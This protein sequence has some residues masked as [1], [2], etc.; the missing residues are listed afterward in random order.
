MKLAFSHDT[1]RPGQEELFT[2]VANALAQKKH[3]LAHAPTGIGKTAAVLTPALDFALHHDLTIFFLTSRHTQHNIVL[4]TVHKLNERN[5]THFPVTSLIGKKHLCAQENVSTMPASDFTSFCKTL[6]EE[7][8]CEY[9]TN[10]RGKNNLAAQQL[11]QILKMGPPVSSEQVMARSAQH[12][13]CPY[14]I[15]LILA[16]ES[17]VIIADYYYLFHPKI[18]ETLLGK[19]KKK[20]EKCIVIVDEGHNLPSRIRDLL[21]FR[22]SSKVM[23]LA[24]QEAKKYGLDNILSYLVEIQ[25]VL[26]QLSATIREDKLIK[27]EQFT[28]PVAKI[29]EYEE[30]VEEFS[31]L[32]EVVRRKQ[33]TS[34]IGS[35]AHFLEEWKRKDKGFARVISKDEF[36]ISLS[37]RCLDPALL[38]K[39]VFD[40]CY[41]AIV[42]SATLQPL[43]MYADVLGLPNAVQKSF[44]S[45]FPESNR[46]SL[47]IPK[48]TTKFALRSEHQYQE[49]ARVCAD[50]ANTVPGC[51][52]LFFPCYRVRD[53][54]ADH[55]AKNYSHKIFYEKPGMEKEEKKKLLDT[56]SLH[57]KSAAALLAV[58]AGSFGEGIDLPG[59]LKG[60]IVVGLPLDKPDLE[61][62][63]L[64]AYY[65]ATFGKGWEYGYI[66]PAMS[67]C[68]QNAGRCIRSE[69]DRGVVAFVDERYA[70]PRYNSAFPAEWNTRTTLDY[71]EQIALFFGKLF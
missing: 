5:N 33:R 12:K 65:D 54:V 55:F 27:Q 15:S 11:I 21:T 58:A 62:T 9:Y 67:R 47:I 56:F 19:L 40:A 52:L 46:L 8:A 39:E 48:T 14:E 45:P 59:I 36:G 50:I 25:D 20:L 57:T 30:L 23:K 3:V 31:T 42:M 32:A 66:L 60:V 43:S 69:R 53:A 63:Q 41:S 17:R 28:T 38:T 24:I 18:R 51:V 16:E 61:T 68:I 70:W 71:R 44:T 7:N 1:I 35:V 37:N 26:N 29:K 34:H 13:L 2:T 10:A 6:V 64:I 49:I 4:E 22:L